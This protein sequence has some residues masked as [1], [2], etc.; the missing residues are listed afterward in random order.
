MSSINVRPEELFVSTGGER[1]RRVT[2]RLS[3]TS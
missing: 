1:R 2:R 3:A